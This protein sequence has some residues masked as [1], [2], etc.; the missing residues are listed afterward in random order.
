MNLYDHSKK[1]G[2]HIDIYSYDSWTKRLEYIFEAELV[3]SI[4]N[5]IT[6]YYNSR[7]LIC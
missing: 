6:E 1:R 3:R 2:K 5:F 7:V 4:L